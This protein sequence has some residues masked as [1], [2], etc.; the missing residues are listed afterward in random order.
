[1]A[2]VYLVKLP[3]DE[4]HWTLLMISQHW[5]RWWL[6]AVRQ[7]AI[8]WV[9]VDPDLCRHMVS[10]GHNELNAFVNKNERTLH[11]DILAQ[12]K[13]NYRPQ[14]AVCKG[15]YDRYFLINFCFHLL[16]RSSRENSDMWRVAS[17]ATAY[18]YCDNPTLV[19]PFIH[20]HIHVLHVTKP[21]YN[22]NIDIC[23]IQYDKLYGPKLQ[24]YEPQT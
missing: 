20:V 15:Q 16:H 12:G 9:N 1:M 7:Q 19:G 13:G 11:D 14:R 3:S 18:A 17:N 10:L 23:C 8:T 6:G 5:F 24:S 4:S 21:L 2:E 22:I